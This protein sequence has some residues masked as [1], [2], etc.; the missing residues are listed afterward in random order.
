MLK[1]EKYL[2]AGLRLRERVTRCEGVGGASN[3]ALGGGEAIVG[4]LGCTSAGSSV[5]EK[6]TEFRR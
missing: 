2:T 1:I 3:E 5:I 6:N 4:E